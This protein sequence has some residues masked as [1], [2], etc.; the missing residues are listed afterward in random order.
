[1]VGLAGLFAHFAAILKVPPYTK[2]TLYS[3]NNMCLKHVTELTRNLKSLLPSFAVLSFQQ[4]CA[5]MCSLGKTAL[6]DITSTSPQ[7]LVATLPGMFWFRH[8][9]TI[10]LFSRCN[11]ASVSANIFLWRAANKGPSMLFLG[12][13]SVFGDVQ[14]GCS[15]G[16]R[17]RKE[18]YENG[19]NMDLENMYIRSN[20]SFDSEN[21]PKTG[22]WHNY[23][24]RW[25]DVCATLRE[26]SAGSSVPSNGRRDPQRKTH[27]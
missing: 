5:K 25:A 13:Y 19:Y 12:F 26:G 23:P 27:S 17:D 18:R 20:W 8:A 21:T 2:F 10:L 4:V 7:G 9:T 14:F 16:V 1:M 3:N 24:P 15:I 11:K 6:C 22:Y